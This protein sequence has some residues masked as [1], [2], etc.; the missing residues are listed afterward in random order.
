M[1][2]HIVLSAWIFLLLLAARTFAQPPAD[3]PLIP[4]NSPG[5]TVAG[6]PQNVVP[7]DPPGISEGW[8]PGVKDAS[9]PVQLTRVPRLDQGSLAS[10][11]S[12]A[13]SSQPGFLS[14]QIRQANTNDAALNGVA[15]LSPDEIC[16]VGNCG[17]I[18]R[19]EDAGRSW[20]EIPSPTQEHLYDV[21][22]LDADYG[23]AVGGGVGN[24]TGTSRGVLLRTL[25]GGRSWEQLPTDLPCLFAL[26]HHQ[27]TIVCRGHYDPQRK[28]SIFVSRDRGN[29]WQGSGLRLGHAVS[30]AQ[31][32]GSITGVDRLG[33]V[34][35]IDAQLRSSTAPLAELGDIAW[36]IQS[37]HFTGRGWIACGHHGLAK[38]SSDGKTW[39][40]IPVP[41]SKQAAQ[42]CHWRS[43]SQS[44]EHV[45]ICGSPGSI[46]LHSPDGGLSWKLEPTG[47]S[48]PLRR[49]Q[50]VDEHRGWAIGSLGKI[51]AT[52]DGGST[53]YEQRGHGRRTGVLAICDQ[54]QQ[55]PWPALAA[56]AWDSQVTTVC[57][58]AD[59]FQPQQ[60]ADFTPPAISRLSN[61]SRG[62]GI[63]LVPI[64]QSSQ[65]PPP[66]GTALLAHLATWR[67]DVVVTTQLSAIAL[68]G[69]TEKPINQGA[70]S[71]L[72]ELRLRPEKPHKLVSLTSAGASQYSEHS[73][74]V[75]KQV[76]LAVWDLLGELPPEDLQSAQVASMRTCWASSTN[77]AASAS[78]MGAV[79]PNE[80]S[81]RNLRLSN[82]GNYQL[83]MGRVH[84][85]RSLQ[86]LLEREGQAADWYQDLRFLLNNLPAHEVAPALWRMA[87]QLKETQEIGRWQL[88][89]HLLSEQSVAPDAAMW[90]MI[91]LLT[92][93]AS[94][95]FRVWQDA[96]RP[97]QT[98]PQP[99]AAG[100]VTAKHLQK[101][102]WNAS[103]FSPQP[104]PDAVV[105]ASTQSHAASQRSATNDALK[106]HESWFRTYG[107]FCQAE[108]RLLHRP[109][110]Q[111]I[112]Y[113]MGQLHAQQTSVEINRLES[114]LEARQLTRWQPLA[115]QELLFDQGRAAEAGL[116]SNAVFAASRPL[117][118]GKLSEVY[119]SLTDCC[120]LSTVHADGTPSQVRFAYDDQY[121]YVALQCPLSGGTQLPPLSDRR[122]YD[123]DLSSLDHLV[124][125]LD[126]NRDYAS[127]FEFA[128]ASDGRTYDR[129][130]G[131][132]RFNPKW[133]VAVSHQ[134]T[135]WTAELAID[136]SYLTAGEPIVDQVWSLSTYRIQSGE[137]TETWTR[138][139]QPRLQD[140]GLLHFL[141]P[142]ASESMLEPTDAAGLE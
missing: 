101:S 105:T 28:T 59:A 70:T 2:C 82:L 94:L 108:P 109:D 72:S 92:M 132:K 55:I 18:L 140:A 71:V 26:S 118:D 42:L 128:V 106:T 50:F 113:R 88:V 83:V 93:N 110:L 107:Q 90:A 41:L 51:L 104:N 86:T 8:G 116:F 74:R 121:L 47:Q 11:S 49:V 98:P 78:L 131:V 123:S 112:A 111:L 115:L 22:F 23:L 43:I 97:K 89:L 99:A 5:S 52:R 24:Y 119:W 100:V 87:I 27:G 124:L 67:P 21:L 37:L 125:H 15:I 44:A 4:T 58:T 117:L 141:P 80:S 48:L 32:A 20:S 84:R 9:L 75:L 133:H 130:T 114:I 66:S 13:S 63:E 17:T 77:Q 29:L 138:H 95:E 122:E 38:F 33:R 61:G 134:P 120:Q 137:R 35:N 136:L 39:S 31:I 7:M 60:Q 54:P 142:P 3:L 16:V 139:S 85:Q 25:D 126:T 57:I 10:A 76:G 73:H 45:W 69:L 135:H 96:T 62:M 19:S 129:L 36:Q 6:Y 64:S 81:N 127:H 56:S 91:E 103:P 14:R 102:P 1:R 40:D 79:P 12:A 46:L 53:W 68:Q 65:A 30:A 34:A